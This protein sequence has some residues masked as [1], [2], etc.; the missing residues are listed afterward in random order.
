MRQSKADAFRPE[1]YV[2]PASAAVEA[3]VLAAVQA[4]LAALQR[5]YPGVAVARKGTEL[6]VTI[7]DT[8]RVGHEAHFAQVTSH[9]LKYFRDRAALPAYFIGAVLVLISLSHDFNLSAATIEGAWAV[10]AAGGLA[11]LAWRSV[12]SRTGSGM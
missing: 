8:F 1:L 12:R 11:R 4:R 3:Q 2:I 7:P 9:F 6:H 5:D 10:I